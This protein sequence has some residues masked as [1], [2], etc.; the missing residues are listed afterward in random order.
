MLL[1][2]NY[3]NTKLNKYYDVNNTKLSELVGLLQDFLSVNT[4]EIGYNRKIKNVMLKQIENKDSII[5]IKV[6]DFQSDKKI[7][8]LIQ[9]LSEEE[10]EI[11]VRLALE[12]SFNCNLSCRK[13]I[14]VQEHPVSAV[15]G[16]TQNE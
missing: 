2:N 16:V 9:H 12:N 5:F 6:S 7:L 15:H 1:T 4:F 13:I 8:W 3:S 11:A 10:I 14:C